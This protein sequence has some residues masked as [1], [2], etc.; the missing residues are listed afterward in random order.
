M[1]LSY[2][3]LVRFAI[4]LCGMAGVLASVP[5]QAATVRWKAEKFEYVAQNKPVREF[6]QEFGASQGLTVLVSKGV[7]GTVNGK[8]DILP[9]SLIALMAAN[10]GF[11]WF[12]DGSVLHVQPASEVR[13]EVLRVGNGGVERLRQALTRLDIPDP[14]Y[15]ITYDAR[16]GTV[17]VSGPGLY[18]DLVVQTARVVG[19]GTAEGSEVRVVPLRWAWAADHTVTQSGRERTLPGVASVMGQLHGT[20]AQPSVAQPSMRSTVDKLRGLGLAAVAGEAMRPRQSPSPAGDDPLAPPMGRG[21]STGVAGPLPQFVADGRLNAVLVR[22]LSERLAGHEA[23]I[24]ALDVKPGLIEIEAR[25]IE[26]N[27]EDAESLGIDWRARSRRVDVQVGRPGLPTLGWG[28]ALSEEAPGVGP[29]GPRTP[30][31]TPT[32]V[33]TTVLGDA[34]RHLIARVSALAQEGKANLL[35]SPKVM[36][37]DNVEAALEDLDTFFVR[38]QGNLDVDLFNVSSGT[39]LRVTPLIIDEGGQ[40]QVKLAIRIEDGVISGNTVDGIPIVRRSTITTQSL[41]GDGQALLI[42]GYAREAS[43]NNRSGVPGLQSVPA[44]GWLF[45]NT[46]RSR[47]RVD[48]FFLLTPRIVKP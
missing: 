23:T 37:L 3:P 20:A 44:L 21:L 47:T 18:V 14:R 16:Q 36:T 26:V 25:I 13:T 7:E 29:G 17:L 8:F 41:I 6:L 38:L 39:S 45:K 46:D 35:S 32:G 42:A 5:A 9:Q 28:S 10:F 40:G 33:L 30:T 4:A 31:P 34:G 11:V 19:Q 22:D 2:L 15:P 27:T 24:R 1:T 12:Y 43:N 48:R